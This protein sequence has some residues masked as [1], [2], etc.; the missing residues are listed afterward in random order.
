MAESVYTDPKQQ[1]TFLIKKKC[2]EALG[3][4]KFKQVFRIIKNG[5]KNKVPRDKLES[6][7]KKVAGPENLHVCFTIQSLLVLESI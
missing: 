5:V 1:K 2:V 3:E 4:K 6:R 7:L